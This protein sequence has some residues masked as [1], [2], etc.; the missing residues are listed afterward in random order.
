MSN[1]LKS[2]KIALKKIPMVNYVV[3][4]IRNSLRNSF[5]GSKNYW[6]ERYAT[7]GNSGCG[8]YGQLAKYKA[9]FLNNFIKE[10]GISS[11]I[12]F[13]CGDGNQL[14]YAEYPSYIGIDVAARAVKLCEQKFS[15]DKTKHF[16]CS[17]S[18]SF[19]EKKASLTSDLSL[20]LDVIYHL[21]ED[22]VFEAYMQNVFSA[23]SKFVI[24]YSSNFD[25]NN[26]TFHVRHRKFTDWVEL[27]VP[28]WKLVLVEKNKYPYSGDNETGSLADFFIYQNC[29]AWSD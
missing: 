16:L 12:E 7:G 5:P 27:Q 10:R 22:E 20:S 6:E 24:I 17:L 13:G 3:I 28:E 18:E 29:D 19:E 8:S 21:I 1:L 11:V 15:K 4:T 23:A 25:Q 26:S 2:L 9:E 14:A